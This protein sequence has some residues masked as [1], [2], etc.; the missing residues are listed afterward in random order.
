MQMT[1]AFFAG[2]EAEELPLVST[3]WECR[4]MIQTL[5]DLLA[6]YKL[7]GQENCHQLCSAGTTQRQIEFQCLVIGPLTAAGFQS[8][9]APSCICSKD[10]TSEAQ[11]EGIQNK[12][13]EMKDLLREWWDITKEE[14]PE[15]VYLIPDPDE[16]SLSKLNGGGAM[17]DTCATAQKENRMLAQLVNG[18]SL[19]C[20][21]HISKKRVGHNNIKRTW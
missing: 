6:A 21:Y 13:K 16:L 3:I 20:H 8:V 19:Y 7:A 10:E 2:E 4:A 1:S 5:N 15:F 18:H 9:I 17:T 12:I 11:V 14:Y